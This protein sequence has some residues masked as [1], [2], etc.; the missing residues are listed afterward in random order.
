MTPIVE[1][2]HIHKIY[3]TGEVD[4]YMRCAMSVCALEKGEFVA[5]MGASGSGKSTMMNILGPAALTGHLM[6]LTGWTPW[7]YRNWIGTSWRRFATTRLDL[8]FRDSTC[9]R[10][11]RRWKTRSCR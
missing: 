11:L 6:G 10:A 8:Y 4:V 7:T 5:I 1:L 2:N 3:H 9:S